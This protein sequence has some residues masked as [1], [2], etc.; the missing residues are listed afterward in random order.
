M[1]VRTR[2]WLIPT[3]A[4]ARRSAAGS[5]NSASMYI[6]I[7]GNANAV[8]LGRDRRVQI[9]QRGLIIEPGAFGM[10]PSTS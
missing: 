8:T 5:A 7:S 6:G 9:G 2:T 4:R 1:I 3:L 10:N